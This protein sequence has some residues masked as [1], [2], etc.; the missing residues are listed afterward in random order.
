MDSFNPNDAISQIENL[1]PASKLELRQVI[2]QE[3][4][5]VELQKRISTIS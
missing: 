1:D 4:Q 3:S 5:K 2:Q